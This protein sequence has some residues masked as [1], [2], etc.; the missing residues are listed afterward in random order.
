MPYR[1]ASFCSHNNRSH[2]AIVHV[3]ATA[4]R[5]SSLG[6]PQNVP[7]PGSVG[8]MQRQGSVG[9]P[10]TPPMPAQ[11]QVGLFTTEMFFCILYN[12]TPDMLF[13]IFDN[14]TSGMLFCMF[15]NVT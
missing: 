1:K 10:Q 14:L 3:Q 15:D 8:G 12:P 11:R 13:C 9:L 5:Q 2:T 6:L 4:Q 7:R